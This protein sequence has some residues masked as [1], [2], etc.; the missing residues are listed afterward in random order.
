MNVCVL[1]Q[2]MDCGS[3]SGR[4]EIAHLQVGDSSEWTIEKRAMWQKWTELHKLCLQQK[5]EMDHTERR[6]SKTVPGSSSSSRL[7]PTVVSKLC[8]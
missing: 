8:G 5:R 2:S 7:L 1:L 6:S 4:A 3:T